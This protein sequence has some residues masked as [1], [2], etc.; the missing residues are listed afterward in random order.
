M[1]NTD[2]LKFYDTLFGKSLSNDDFEKKWRLEQ[3]E[4]LKKF[5]PDI[6]EL[7]NKEFNTSLI[8]SLQKRYPKYSFKLFNLSKRSDDEKYLAV[9]VNNIFNDG[10]NLIFGISHLNSITQFM[11]NIERI[12]LADVKFI[13]DYIGFVYE[14]TVEIGCY[15]NFKGKFRETLEKEKKLLHE[16]L[17]KNTP[18]LVEISNE[19]A[20]YD[21]LYGYLYYDN[22]FSIKITSP[23][24]QKL[25]N[26]SLIE[27]IAIIEENV[28][29][30]VY[31]Q[32]NDMFELLTEKS[33][34][35]YG[36][37][38]Y[39]YLKNPRIKWG[40]VKSLKKYNTWLLYYIKLATSLSISSPFKYL[41]YYNVIEHNFSIVFENILKTEFNSLLQI[42]ELNI[43][44]F[45]EFINI[46]SKYS[47]EEK[48]LQTVLQRYIDLE[49]FKK[50]FNINSNIP[51]RQLTDEIK[52]SQIVLHP[53]EFHLSLARHI[54]QIRNSIVH[55]KANFNEKS[56]FYFSKNKVNFS[57]MS[58]EI[59]L[60]K[61][62]AEEILE[63]TTT[64]IN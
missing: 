44:N 39:F 41:A 30:I 15:S 61:W 31:Y 48:Q 1:N 27:L 16:F 20:I 3:Y 33:K 12:N 18:I 57:I 17:Y 36:Q 47:Q 60:V 62:V 26:D 14:E 35:K 9:E 28:S 7:E 54:Y 25:D 55:S 32:Y 8:D 40:E 6:K 10:H 43:K 29:N 59:F 56:P 52:T 50:V 45:S 34:Y 46:Y 22:M 11:K 4:E 63:K 37:H 38:R 53:D 58:D 2:I 13:S 51:E 19:S 42:P 23:L 5:L 49:E 64:E 24:I 21:L